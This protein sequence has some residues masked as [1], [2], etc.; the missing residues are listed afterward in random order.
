MIESE[1]REMSIFEDFINQICKPFEQQFEFKKDFWKDNKPTDSLWCRINLR[2]G[3]FFKIEMAH[4]YYLYNH[5]RFN[6]QESQRKLENYLMK[7]NFAEPLQ[8]RMGLP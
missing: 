8:F 1:H 3:R 2:D 7:N 5:T 4:L 6:I